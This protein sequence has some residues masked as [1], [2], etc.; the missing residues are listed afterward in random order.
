MTPATDWQVCPG[1]LQGSLEPPV[2]KSLAHRVLIASWLAE[3]YSC[4]ADGLDRLRLTRP[5]SE[6]L[7]ATAGALADWARLGCRPESG[8]AAP[9]AG[10]AS[11]WPEVDMGESGT[12]LRL[13]LPV[14]AALQSLPGSGPGTPVCLTGHGRL[15]FRP[16]TDLQTALRAAGARLEPAG[17]AL[18]DRSRV[19]PLAVA[20][21]LNAGTF[22]LPGNISSQYISGLLFALPLLPGT[23]RLRLSTAL[24]SSGYVRMTE[25][26]LRCYGI[27]FS[28][29]SRDGAG[30]S[31]TIPGGQRYCCPGD[32]AAV[33]A[34]LETDCSQAAFWLTA[35]YIGHPLRILR[36]PYPSLQGDS[37]ISSIL[38]ALAAWR[39]AW[40]TENGLDPDWTPLAAGTSASAPLPALPY[41]PLPAQPAAACLNWGQG[42]WVNCQE[43]PDL[44]PIVALAAA[45]TPGCHYLC[46]L[47][48]LRYKESDRLAATCQSLNVLGASL[49][50]GRMSLDWQPCG[51]SQPDFTPEV[52]GSGSPQ[53]GPAALRIAGLEPGQKLKG[54]VGYCHHDHRLAMMLSVAATVAAAPI[55]L[56]DPAAVAKSYP[57]FWSDWESLGGHLLHG[58][59]T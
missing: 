24:E 45:L 42:I 36:L 47:D 48:R 34:L 8:G 7:A 54:Q 41:G 43:V 28:F 53:T 26:V 57:D 1:C 6:D 3:P 40:L 56:D 37:S 39:R 30:G 10:T 33:T 4:T 15:P 9:A 2:S 17:E 11:G 55:S 19:L 44:V 18:R 13:L 35:V 20:A 52:T 58:E 38:T 21:G 5:A 12:T 31:W 22:T 29:D 50:P 16:L 27:S 23:S 25:A 32:P 46:G 49:Q 14:F 59:P 51:G